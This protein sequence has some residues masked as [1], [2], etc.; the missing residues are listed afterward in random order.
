MLRIFIH[1]TR[2]ECLRLLR[3]P[4]FSGPVI[5]FPA[6]FY[7]LFGILMGRSQNDPEILRQTL[8]RFI[9]FG[10]LAPG[11]FGLGVTLAL[12]RERGLLQLK[13]ALPMPAGAYLG[14]KVAMSMVF[15]GIVCVLLLALGLTG[16]HIL[17]NVYQC[18]SLFG[19]SVFGVLP[20]CGLGLLIGT[21]VKGSAAP[22][23][24]NLVYL[25]MSFLSGLLIPLES[26]PLALQQLAPALPPYH[27]AQLAL[28]AIGVK[29]TGGL[30][31]HSFI[32][33][34]TAIVLFAIAC[35]RLQKIR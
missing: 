21:V 2:I 33:A 28:A 4:A 32:P 11:L 34:L 13:R 7:V 16:A 8:A 22:A 20:F 31:M 35:R 25:P 18:V 19:L 27:L 6:L 1:E 5:L 29:N 12:E 26:L 14:A 24:L 3:T 23:V 30:L 17:L 10:T 15:A 9:I